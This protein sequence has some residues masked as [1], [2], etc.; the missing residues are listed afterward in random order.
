M[1]DPHK[2]TTGP[3][4]TIRS[5]RDGDAGALARVAGRDSATLP[6]APLLVA[7]VDGAIRAAVSLADGTHI[8][9]PFHRTEELV[10]ML[11]IRARAARTAAPP[12]GATF[13]MRR[14]RRA[15]LAFRTAS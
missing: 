7:E 2:I 3:E 6:R 10:A 8:A 9:D 15:R 4:I 11:L 1:N 14:A 5:A 13:T 12:A